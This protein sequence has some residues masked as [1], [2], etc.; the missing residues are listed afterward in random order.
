M[1]SDD[2]IHPVEVGDKFAEY[3][4]RSDGEGDHELIGK[5][6][7]FSYFYRPSRTVVDHV[8]EVVDLGGR[9]NG[10]YWISVKE[11]SNGTVFD[12]DDIG[13]VRSRAR[14][15]AHLGPLTALEIES[16]S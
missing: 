5:R 16:D 8:G 7:A 1:K 2:W 13:V 11:S 9:N 14:S 10:V 3:D 4:L 6:V 12:L 15:R